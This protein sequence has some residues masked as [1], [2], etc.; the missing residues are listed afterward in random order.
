M[1]DDSDG[2]QSTGQG[3][4]E[5]GSEWRSDTSVT[6]REFLK[7]RLMA[8]WFPKGLIH[9]DSFEPWN[10]CAEADA[11]AIVQALAELRSGEEK[12]RGHEPECLVP[13]I[14]EC[15]CTELKMCEERVRNHVLSSTLETVK[16]DS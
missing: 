5:F 11:E 4:D 12:F 9:D 16:E 14:R 8:S 7:E 3:W 2:V 6:L 15:I 1:R 10:E 13:W